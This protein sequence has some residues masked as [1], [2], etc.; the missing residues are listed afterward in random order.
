VTPVP[1]L[2]VVESPKR[3]FNSDA[4]VF[5]VCAFFVGG[6]GGAGIIQWKHQPP[7]TCARSIDGRALITF[8]IDKEG[9]ETR[10]LYEHTHPPIVTKKGKK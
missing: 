10:C 7:T 8:N 6:L 9:N 5:A 1:K 3:E 4:V 2:Q